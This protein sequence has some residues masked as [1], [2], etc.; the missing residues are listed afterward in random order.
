MLCKKLS[1]EIIGHYSLDA[2]I[3]FTKKADQR[4]DHIWQNS[5]YLDSRYVKTGLKQGFI[6]NMYLFFCSAYF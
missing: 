4:S 6:R 5:K 1:R 2:S 3:T